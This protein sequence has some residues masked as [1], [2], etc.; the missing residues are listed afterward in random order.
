MP[1][2]NDSLRA[3]P[4]S[5]PSLIGGMGSVPRA[6]GVDLDEVPLDAVLEVETGHTTYRLE[7]MGNGNVR[8]SGHPKYCPE[9]TMVQVQGSISPIGELKWHFLGIGLKLIFLPAGHDVIR[10]SPI[11]SVR[12]I[13]S[14][15]HN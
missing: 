9:P 3:E 2:N 1:Y 5:N 4:K 14:G 8:I 13:A 6:E 10:T 12:Q 11:K 7:N 15:P